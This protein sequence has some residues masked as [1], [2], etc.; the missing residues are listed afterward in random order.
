MK[1]TLY[2]FVVI[3]L[4]GCMPPPKDLLKVDQSTL[5]IRETQS[6]I[7]DSCTDKQLLRASVSVLQDMGYSIK[8][9]VMDY[10]VLT[11]VKQADATSAGQ[12]IGAIAVAFLSGAVQ[13]IDS[14]QHITATIVVLDRAAPNQA[15]ARTTFQR[16]VVRTDNSCYAH[17]IIDQEVY[18]EFYEKLD[19]SLFLEVNK[20]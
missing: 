17:N 16:V 9:S 12:V 2:L 7:F 4:T 13:P 1:N 20:V 8:E 5:Q 6:R 14:T 3:F 10:G 19:K 15:T 18:K 11:A